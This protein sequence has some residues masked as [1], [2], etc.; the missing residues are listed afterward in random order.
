MS[1]NIRFFRFS[2]P[3][4]FGVVMFVAFGVAR[5]EV[6]TYVTL[7]GHFVAE[8]LKRNAC[9]PRLSGGDP[10]FAWEESR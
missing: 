9:L 7:L 4:L 5:N 8:R 3:S 10:W 2:L 6:W 1:S